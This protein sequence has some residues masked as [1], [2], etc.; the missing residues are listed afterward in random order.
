MIRRLIIPIYIYSILLSVF[1]EQK[2][3]FTNKYTIIIQGALAIIIFLLFFMLCKYENFYVKDLLFFNA[4]IIYTIFNYLITIQ[5]YLGEISDIVEIFVH[6]LSL[7]FYLFIL[8][9]LTSLNKNDLSIILKT[10]II[11]IFC[12][13]LIYFLYNINAISNIMK[14]RVWQWDYSGIF[15]NRNVFGTYLFFSF[16]S[17]VYIML[18]KFSWKYLAVLLFLLINI[19]LTLSRTALLGII[20]FLIVLVWVLRDEII[21]K[22]LRIIVMISFV[23]FL[24]L[25]VKT[26]ISIFIK[27]FVLRIGAGTSGRSFVWNKGLKA[28]IASPI[29]GMGINSEQFITSNFPGGFHNLYLEILTSGGI[30][31]FIL[32]MLIFYNLFRKLTLVKYYDKF[33]YAYAVAMIFAWLIMAFFEPLNVFHLSGRVGLSGIF[34][35][36]LPLSYISNLIQKINLSSYECKCP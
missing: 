15:G 1:L 33:Y 29:F 20:T 6:L 19:I 3:I 11:S 22:K 32:Y 34:I 25:F 8:P 10:Y 30:I 9:R 13:C 18:N 4:Y 28:F 27:D 2:N 36:A 5:F 7:L 16:I 12:Y 17:C 24:I 26:D 21:T 35:F 31:L 23:L 14:F